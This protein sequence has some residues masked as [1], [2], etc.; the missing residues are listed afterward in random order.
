MDRI[1]S[2]NIQSESL[3]IVGDFELKNE[4]NTKMRGGGRE[5]SM[6]FL[7]LHN[8]SFLITK[9]ETTTKYVLT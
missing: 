9:Y 4:K 5:R 7:T 1:Q 3:T 2:N 6:N 8:N